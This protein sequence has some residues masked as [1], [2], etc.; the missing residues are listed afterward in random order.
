MSKCGKM[1]SYSGSTPRKFI[2][3]YLEQET[4]G[5]PTQKLA[6]VEEA[7]RNEF[8][9]PD[10]AHD[11]PTSSQQSSSEIKE[12]EVRQLQA[13]DPLHSNSRVIAEGKDIE[14]CPPQTS[15]LPKKYQ[16]M[17]EA[18][19]TESSQPQTSELP[20]K[21]QPMTEAMD[22]ESSQPQTSELPKKDQPMTEA[23]DT[24]SSQPQ[25][26]E[27]PSSS[28]HVQAEVM[29]IGISQ[30]QTP[31]EVSPLS[32]L[33]CSDGSESNESCQ[34]F[35]TRKMQE[36]GTETNEEGT[37][38]DHDASQ[39]ESESELITVFPGQEQKERPDRQFHQ[40]PA[41]AFLDTVTAYSA[42][43]NSSAIGNSKKRAKLVRPAT[44]LRPTLQDDIHSEPS[45]APSTTSIGLHHG[46]GESEQPIRMGS[47]SDYGLETDAESSNAGGSTMADALTSGRYNPLIEVDKASSQSASLPPAPTGKPEPLKV[48]SRALLKEY[49]AKTEPVELLRGHSTIAL[50]EDQISSVLRIVA[51]ETARASYDMLENLVYRAS[52]LSLNTSVPGR[53]NV[54]SLSQGSDEGESEIEA[55]SD[56][57]GGIRSDDDF[58][59]FGYAY[60][61]S[62]TEI[63]GRPPTA[64]LI[65]GC[66]SNDQA[67][68][69]LEFS[70]NGPGSQTLA[71]LQREAL[72]D[73]SSSRG[74]PSNR[75]IP[76]SR[77]R[78][79]RPITR[80]CK[81]MKEAYFK[82]MEWTKTFVSG[83][84]DLRWNPYK[85]YCQICKA[86]IS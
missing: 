11:F 38:A 10:T 4:N 28:Q 29:Q 58:G 66:G 8:S 81:I 7:D 16:P 79:R 27:A 20:N 6:E 26:H 24:E 57:S 46:F 21:D 15:E 62:E 74:K 60:E 50:T 30:D 53:S 44:P 83:P 9:I 51:D 45:I 56:T 69:D 18:M 22:T 64:Q 36:L 35:F 54:R 41:V 76:A 85:F 55:G 31:T 71:A 48:S 40:V 32:Q 73:Q 63:I 39:K 34:A 5:Q 86:N 1:D 72:Q 13:P 17:T 82:G 52:R 19:D 68:P 75:R 23:M 42:S 2:S 80:S 67:S 49:F 37:L 47:S 3:F 61:H 65:P 33:L 12:N 59:S 14:L 78:T 77:G 43:S 70:V 84:V 25:I